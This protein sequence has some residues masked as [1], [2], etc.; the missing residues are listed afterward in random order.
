M[1]TNWVYAPIFKGGSTRPYERFNIFHKTPDNYSN[2][3]G[4]NTGGRLKHLATVR[5]MPSKTQTE[6]VARLIAAAPDLL[7]ALNEIVTDWEHCGCPALGGVIG[8]THLRRA[9]AAIDK[10][11]GKTA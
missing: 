11:T 9:R 2:A 8:L 10:A 4:V 5:A 3:Y 7:A 6:D 1:L